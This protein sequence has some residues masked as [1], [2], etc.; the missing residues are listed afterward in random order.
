M[1]TIEKSLRLINGE[2]TAILTYTLLGGG[3]ALGLDLRPLLALRPIH[4]LTKQWDGQVGPEVRGQRYFRVPATVRTPEVFFAHTGIFDPVA[5]DWYLNTVYR[6]ELE[7]GY[8]GVEDL[9][10]PG[11][12]RFTLLPGQPIHLICSTDPIDLERVLERADWQR[13]S[14]NHVIVPSHVPATHAVA[15]PSPDPVYGRLVAAANQF[16]LAGPSDGTGEKPSEKSVSVIGQYPWGP[17][18]ARSALIGFSGLFLVPGRFGDARSLLL[19]LA[20]TEKNG[21]IPASTPEDGSAYQYQYDAADVSLWFINAVFHY[22]RYTADVATLNRKLLNTVLQ[23]IASY[24]DT[25]DGTIGV[26]AEGLLV[27]RTAPALVKKVDADI[28]EEQ[29]VEPWQLSRAV[30]QNALWYNAACIAADL[31]DRYGSRDAATELMAFA[32]RIK[33]SFNNQ[34]WNDEAGCCFNRVDDEGVDTSVRPGQLLAVSLPFPVLSLDRHAN[35][36]E[37]VREQLFTPRGLRTLSPLDREYMGRYEGNVFTRDRAHCNGSVHP[38]LMGQYVTALLRV[39]GQGQAA[40]DEA[41]GALDGI[42]DF[43]SGDGLGRICELFDGDSPH[44]PGGA[45]A[46]AEST[47][48]IL[49]AYAEEVLELGPVLPY[50]AS[51]AMSGSVIAPRQSPPHV[52]NPA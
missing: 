36:L 42:F 4:E 31:S 49:R 28:N 33:D 10:S 23:I 22:M 27:K 40:R 18:S 2:N 29:P 21:L 8:A 35:L 20:A 50:P 43:L 38:W 15:P 26:D 39:R 9:W 34:F 1:G 47:G 12:V 41:R 17:P 37:K 45:I 7:R 3:Q 46:S 16:I 19:S 5:A 11:V 25:A 48:E 32:A 14:A 13:S 30:D 51:L 52:E 24:R 44:R 6:R